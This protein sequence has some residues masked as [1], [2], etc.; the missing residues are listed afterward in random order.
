VIDEKLIQRAA[1]TGIVL[2]L[3]MVIIA[4][5]VSWL[6][7]N[8][9]IFGMMMI[10][11][12]AGLLYARDFAKGYGR[13]ALGGAIAGGTCGIIGVSAANILGDVPL[14]SLPVGA[15]ITILVGAIGGL[16]G[17]MAANIRKLNA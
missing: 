15:A 8:T 3:A 4:H 1:V 17:Q 11:G 10:S 5:Y 2:Q 6:A 14:L 12:L 9:Y 16:F 7:S 13:G